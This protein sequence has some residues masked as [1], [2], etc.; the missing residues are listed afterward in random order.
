MPSFELSS[1]A[2]AD[3]EKILRYTIETWGLDQAR[4]MR[5]LKRLAKAWLM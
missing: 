5:T 4:Q 2:D 1:L 3:L